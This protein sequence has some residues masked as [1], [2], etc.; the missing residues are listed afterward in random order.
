MPGDLIGTRVDVRADRALVR[1]YARGQ[2]VK[3]HPR[4]APGRR[5]TDAEDLPAERT[6]VP[7][8]GLERYGGE[9][10]VAHLDDSRVWPS[11]C[12]GLRFRAGGRGD[13]GD[14]LDDGAIAGE[15]AAPPV[16]G[17]EAAPRRKERRR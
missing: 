15:G 8:V 11:S 6:A 9:F 10:A 2:L 1:V 16:Y 12:F 13:G 4:E 17:D 7:F 5:V 3:V 14:E